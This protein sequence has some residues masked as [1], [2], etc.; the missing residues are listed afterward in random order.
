MCSLLDLC[1]NTTYSK[2]REK[3]YMQKHGCA[4]GSPVSPIVANLYM[5]EVEKQ[6][7][8]TFKGIAP[9]HWFRYVDDTWVK[10]HQK[11]VQAFTEHINVV[12]QNIKFTREEVQN[13]KLAFL[14]CLV[15]VK[16]NGKLEVE[17]Y[18]K[19][20]HT[21]Q[22]LSAFWKLFHSAYHFINNV[23][24]FCTAYGKE[25]VKMNL[26][27]RI[28]VG[29][30]TS[31]VMC[32]KCENISTVREA[33]IDLS[34]PIIE[35]RVPKPAFFGRASKSK[36]IQEEDITDCTC[37]YNQQLRI[38]KK[39]TPTK[40]KNPLTQEQKLAKKCI[41]DM[42]NES[43]LQENRNTADSDVQKNTIPVQESNA[44][45][46]NFNIVSQS[47]ASEKDDTSQVES[48]GDADSEASEYENAEIQEANKRKIQV[49][50][51]VSSYNE[52]VGVDICQHDNGHDCDND[53]VVGT[54]SKL[55]I[56]VSVENTESLKTD[57]LL[58]IKNTWTSPLKKCMLPQNP[59]AAFQT[60]SQ[61]YI[62]RP[63]ECSVQ[64]C[65][66]Q[67]TSV[68][69]LMGNNKLLCENCAQIQQKNIKKSNSAEKRQESVYTNARKQL[70]ISA[71]PANL[72]LHLKRFYQNGLTL[73]KINRHVDFPLILDL[74]PFCSANCKNVLKEK[75]VLYSL[76][77]I[78]EHS[79]SMRGGH[80][81]A[82]VKIRTPFRK[83]IENNNN[84]SGI[85]ESLG[86]SQWVYVSDTHVQM[87][88]ESR[89]LTAQ[90]Y[91]LF[92][93]KL[94]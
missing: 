25:G 38:Q 77:G 11:E 56:N 61:G 43:F 72:I 16:E 18:R 21:D 55:N 28:F 32:E 64:S 14:D 45:L 90:A 39:H 79:G 8:N 74:A 94:C 29:E 35:E 52:N 67:F 3:F 92:Y 20:T 34:L 71:A 26:I 91:I 24:L 2:Y 83:L 63:K 70:L 81:A 44:L 85:T 73:R 36:G 57:Q 50:E 82:Y 87:V 13:N 51:V 23:F 49:S 46:R 33:F 66:Y 19:P 59:L 86:S 48:S 30:L 9:S 89:V 40:D 62:T 93:E 78:V 84:S 60:L 1:L 7:L 53:A 68:E 37:N 58:G 4:M 76:Y 12:D 17:V 42:N 22:Y 6:A 5:E 80:Y 15:E 27:D 10:I 47:D 88:S 69:L 75:S 31:T 54:L 65:L 41:A